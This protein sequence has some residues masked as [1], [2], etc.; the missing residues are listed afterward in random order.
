MLIF[1]CVVFLVGLMDYT[2]ACS[3]MPQFGSSLRSHVQVLWI[4]SIIYV[5]TLVLFLNVKQTGNW[6]LI[7]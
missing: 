5:L 2:V 7:W 6:G 3:A 4:S 1:L